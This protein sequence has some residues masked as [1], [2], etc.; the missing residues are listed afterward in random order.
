[1]A[2]WKATPE[3]PHNECA[4]MPPEERCNQCRPPHTDE[5]WAEF[6][7]L[8][9]AQPTL[10]DV[11]RVMQAKVDELRSNGIPEVAPEEAEERRRDAAWRHRQWNRELDAQQ[12]AHEAV[13]GRSA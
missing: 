6:V 13:W 12:R 3:T 2:D 9:K 11:V 8:V 7:E 1:M 10:A 4:T 5:D